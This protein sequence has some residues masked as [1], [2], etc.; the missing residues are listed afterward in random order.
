MFKLMELG[1]V[2]VQEAYKTWNMGVGMMMI[3]DAEK[4]DGLIAA[5]QKEEVESQVIGYVTG[6]EEIQF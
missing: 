5:L 6:G 4:A 3:A 1:Q 2:S